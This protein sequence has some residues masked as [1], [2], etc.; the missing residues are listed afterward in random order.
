MASLLRYYSGHISDVRRIII[1]AWSLTTAALGAT[2]DGHVVNS[3]TGAGIPAVPVSLMQQEHLL[4]SATTDAQGRFQIDDVKPGTYKPEFRQASKF[5]LPNEALPSAPPFQVSADGTP[6]H[7]EIKLPPLG[8]LSGKVLDSAGV[9][10]PFAMTLLSL[11]RHRYTLRGSKPADAKGEYRFDDLPYPGEWVVSA[12]GPVYGKPLVSNG[13]Q[14]LEW[15]QTYYPGVIDPGAA[16]RIMLPQSGELSDLDIKLKAVPV[17]RIRG[18][19][20]DL[21]GE[22]VPGASV[23]LGSNSNI[24]PQTVLCKDD[25]TFEFASATDGVRRLSAT[26]ERE[27]VTLRASQEIEINGHD[28][29]DVKVRLMAPFSIRGRVAV[30]VPEGSPAP[31]LPTIQLMGN[32]P[33]KPDSNGEFVISN[34][35]PGSFSIRP[36][37]P[38][39][40]YYLDSIRIGNSEAFETPVQILSGDQPLAVTYKH[41]GGTIRGTVEKCGT[42][43]VTLV[44]RE[45]A[46]RHPGLIRRTS[47]DPTGKFEIVSVR[48]G[49]YYA[50]ALPAD[51]YLDDFATLDS[52]VVKQSTL[53][54]VVDSEIVNPEIRLIKAK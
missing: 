22:P 38:P 37:S 41:G 16:A 49:E 20:L 33:G 3:V 24:F 52:D 1:I 15:A 36:D 4:Y 8:K 23:I 25:G 40:G 12:M 50:F 44:P 6:V 18:V 43:D 27:G 53:V 48:P 7:L 28:L 47:C 11:E 35:Y 13:D 17:H 5:V 30:E 46:E 10:I 45:A 9:P 14:R 29:D 42:A 54:T 26:V 21:R 51:E 2:V 19:L 34:L 39:P 31:K 32:L